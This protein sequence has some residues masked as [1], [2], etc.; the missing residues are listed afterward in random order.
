[1]FKELIMYESKLCFGS[2]G[3][4]CLRGWTPLSAAITG[5]GHHGS[6]GPGE[7]KTLLLLQSA[8]MV[9]RFHCH[10]AFPALACHAWISWPQGHDSS[11]TEIEPLRDWYLHSQGRAPTSVHRGA[12]PSLL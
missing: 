3:L 12:V 7:D 4:G 11:K 10:T 5:H 1:M 9:V 6:H 2:A 8:L